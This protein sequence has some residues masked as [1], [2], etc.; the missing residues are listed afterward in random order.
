M[1]VLITARGGS[2]G[3]P[4]KNIKSLAGKPLLVWSIESALRCGLKPV[5][6]SDS[7][8]YLELAE[9]H[10]ATGLLRPENLAQDDTPHF[11][12]L[13]HAFENLGYPTEM[14]LFQPTSPF[15]KDRDVQAS[16]E[17]FFKE[18][19]DS[20]I[21]VIPIPEE[22]HPDVA[23]QLVDGRIQMASG[24]PV[25]HRIKRR[26]DHR[27]AY[28]PSGSLYLFKTKN[29]AEG[30]F[31]GNRVGIHEVERTVNIN[32]QRDFD[33]AEEIAKTWKE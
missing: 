4:D 18:D 23:L 12:V 2:K 15:R 27:P 33:L 29:L 7:P 22:F 14:A 3:I 5:V 28:V 32:D 25:K 21:D 24:V 31:Y 16:I 30:S 9:R 11:D 19:Y 10:G 8:S 13:V 20:L 1:I 26:Q 6:S 17:K